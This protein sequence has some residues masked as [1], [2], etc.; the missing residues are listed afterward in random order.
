MNK[1]SRGFSLIEVL[2]VVIVIGVLAAIAIPNLTGLYQGARLRE[3]ARDITS[4]LRRTRQLGIAKAKEY[5]LCVNPST[6]QYMIERG[7]ASDSNAPGVEGCNV[8]AGG[9]E[10]QTEVGWSTLPEGVN[11]NCL[12]AGGFVD[13]TT[14]V[15]TY[16]FNPNGSS[17][18]GTIFL[19]D[20]K[21]NR[22]KVTITSSTTGRVRIERYTGNSDC[23]V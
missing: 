18:T 22:F 5:R 6:E 16:K 10:W 21:G 23:G 19:I 3:A 1:T 15:R 17:S 9:D 20:Q 13:T 2:V 4:E 14:D 12:D 7:Q 11:I 8:V